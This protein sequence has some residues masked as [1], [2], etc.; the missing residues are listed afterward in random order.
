VG[1][2]GRGEVALGSFKVILDEY[3][4]VSAGALVCSFS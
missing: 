2:R 1:G 4:H 3:L